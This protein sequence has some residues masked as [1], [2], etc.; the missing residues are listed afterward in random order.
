MT[1]LPKSRQAA[2]ICKEW[3]ADFAQ[4]GMDNDARF[5]LKMQQQFQSGGSISEADHQTLRHE[6]SVKI[7]AGDTFKVMD[8]IEEIGK[9]ARRL[10]GIIDA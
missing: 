6:I 5:W 9:E 1:K 8:S 4:K 7:Y 2:N 3:S 10:Q